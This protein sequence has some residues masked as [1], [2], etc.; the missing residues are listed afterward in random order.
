MTDNGRVVV[1]GSAN[2]D[3]VV[4]TPRLPTAGE[5]VL[6]GDLLR[7]PGGKGANQAVAAARSGARVRFVGALGGD[8]FGDEL[9]AALLEDGVDVSHVTRV[10]R[11]TGT[12]LIVVD[13]A[14]ENLI[15]VAPG[16]NLALSASDVEAAVDSANVV[17]VQLEIPMPCVLAAL[18]AGR[19]AG[20]RTILNAAPAGSVDVSLVDVL[21]VNETEA[22]M[23]SGSSDPEQAA[24]A[25]HKQGPR[26][27][28][29]T[30]GADGLLL[31]DA[32][33]LTRLAAHAVNVVDATAAG[34]A[35]CGALAAALA[36]GD[37]MQRAVRFANAAAALATT[38]PG[39]QPSLPHLQD[40]LALLG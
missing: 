19:S 25:L 17:L 30:L 10:G 27:V 5:T 9:L 22:A 20:A 1:A 24:N 37:A 3:L 11:P 23:L 29:V 6:G 40:I 39:A 28:I 13:D 12:A 36:R 26:T 31:A 32:D 38:L 8:A 16:A 2:M 35:F 33:G 15:A 7:A 21:I 34:D 14:G 4:H 18:A